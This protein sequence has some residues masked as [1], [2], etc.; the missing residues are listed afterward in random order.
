MIVD[1]DEMHIN[2]KNRVHNR[3]VDLTRPKKVKNKKNF[4]RWE[5]L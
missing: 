3:S 5:K 4:N 1:I 2:I